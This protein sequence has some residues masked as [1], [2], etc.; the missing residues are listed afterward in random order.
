MD[1]TSR[2]PAVASAAQPVGVDSMEVIEY[3]REKEQVK[4]ALAGM[5]TQQQLKEVVEESDLRQRLLDPMAMTAKDREVYAD[6]LKNAKRKLDI[7]RKVR[8]ETGSKVLGG[9]AVVGQELNEEV[10]KPMG[11]V[12]GPVVKGVVSL[13]PIAEG[14]FEELG[15]AMHRLEGTVGDGLTRLTGSRTFGDAVAPS[16]TQAL[17]A[18]APKVP[19]ALK[20]TG[21]LVRQGATALRNMEVTLDS[22]AFLRHNAGIPIDAV[23]I[24]QKTPKVEV[25]TPAP[26]APMV[27]EATVSSG[28][29]TLKGGATEGALTVKNEVPVSYKFISESGKYNNTPVY[30]TSPVGTKQT[31]KVYTRTDINW[32]QI[33]TSGDRRFIGKTNLEAAKHG[34]PPQLEDKSFATLHHLGQDSRGGLVEASTRYHGIGKPGQDVLHS[35]FGRS[36]PNPEYPID[37]PKFNQDTA[38]YWKQRV[39]GLE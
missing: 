29:A 37:R 8:D 4:E 7:G 22:T 27:A 13:N 10:W 17:L 38:A 31:Y 12:I 34:L 15:Q 9:I 20:T 36:K 2:C 21:R 35:Q 5:F 39:E 19:G 16:A 25:P 24:G 3:N 32:Y 14:A 28:E 30:W 18:A 26:T 6:G 23:K 1:A 11:E 33:R